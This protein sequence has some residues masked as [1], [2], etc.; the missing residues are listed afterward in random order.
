MTEWSTVLQ[1]YKQCSL[2]L[3]LNNNVLGE[4]YGVYLPVKI[5]RTKKKINDIYIG[6]NR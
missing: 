6:N 5:C 1:I 3:Y 4:N 2:V